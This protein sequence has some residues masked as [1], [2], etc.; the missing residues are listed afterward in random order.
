MATADTRSLRVVKN[1]ER[2]RK[3][4]KEAAEALETTADQFLECRDLHHPWKVVGLFYVGAEVHRRLVCTRCDTEA[5]DRWTGRGERI[6]RVYSYAEGYK[7]KGVRIT[8]LDVRRE[9]L[10]RVKVY[11]DEDTMMASLFSGRGNNKR[12]RA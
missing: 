9:V 11:Q 10:K 1:S 2:P 6:R 8:A 4:R 3:E 5:T 7:V 12:K